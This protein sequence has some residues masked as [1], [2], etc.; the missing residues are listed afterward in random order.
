[1]CSIDISQMVC[2][3]FEKL[4]VIVVPRLF[5]CRRHFFSLPLLLLYCFVCRPLPGKGVKG[6]GKAQASIDEISNT[7]NNWTGMAF[8]AAQ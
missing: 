5:L 3:S 4:C 8:K 1:M 6:V 2:L 7:N